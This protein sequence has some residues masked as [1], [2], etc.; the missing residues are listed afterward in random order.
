VKPGS[1]AA[2]KPIARTSLRELVQTLRQRKDHT[3]PH[4]KGLKLSA[5]PNSRASIRNADPIIEHHDR[6]FNQE[7]ERIARPSSEALLVKEAVI[8]H[9]YP[10]L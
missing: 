6:A 9:N 2:A 3:K 1:S 4:E 7:T 10:L 5:I 8:Y